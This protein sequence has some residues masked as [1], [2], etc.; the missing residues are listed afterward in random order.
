MTTYQFF[1]ASPTQEASVKCSE[2]FVEC[3]QKENKLIN[4]MALKLNAE[5]S[6]IDQQNRTVNFLV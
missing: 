3:Q 4:L 2:A 6:V 5:L 1:C